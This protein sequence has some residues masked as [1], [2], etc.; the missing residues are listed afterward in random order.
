[1]RLHFERWIKEQ[2]ISSR[3]E[4]LINEAVTCYRGEAYKAALLFSFLSFQ[5]IIK[6]R[7][8]TASKPPGY[9]EDFWNKIQGELRSDDIWE[10]KVI[11]C[12]NRNKPASIFKLT[13]DIKHQYFY[14]KDRRNDCAHAKGNKIDYSHVETFWLFFESNLAKFGV[15]GG[16]E[17]LLERLKIFFDSSLTP[18]DEDPTPIINDIP[19]SVDQSD[20]N[21]VLEMIH[22]LTVGVTLDKSKIPFWHQL[23]SLDGDFRDH[24]IDFLI[25]KKGLCLAILV[26]DPSKVRHFSKDP[27]FIRLLWKE[28]IYNSYKHYRIII[29]LLRHKLI[30]CNQLK[31]VVETATRKINDTLFIRPE[32]NDLLTLEDS[33]FFDEFKTLAF[34]EMKI[35][36]FDWARENRNLVIQY[37]LRFGFDKE[38]VK[39]INNTFLGS[40]IPWK[41]KDS[42]EELFEQKPHLKDEYIRI[43]EKIDG[44]LPEYFF[45]EEADGNV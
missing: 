14:W 45:G 6:E 22:N 15:N 25:T 37:I 13:D 40:F 4:E 44:I 23:F 10:S 3:T 26:D 36:N 32:E 7:M 42:L 16:K 35:K 12:V 38:I 27:T 8:L 20:F 24:L 1:L 31:D 11:E 29:G 34:E 9:K 33:G 5:N 30:P 21:E 39:A 17:S 18:R 43:N 28:M 2:N 41:L 19:S